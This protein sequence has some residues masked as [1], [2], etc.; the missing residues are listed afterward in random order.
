[1]IRV[2]LTQ[3]FQVYFN[4]STFLNKHH[5]TFLFWSMQDELFKKLPKFGKI[6]FGT[7]K[8]QTFSRTSVWLIWSPVLQWRTTLIFAFPSTVAPLLL[9]NGAIDDKQAF[10]DGRSRE[11]LVGPEQVLKI[12]QDVA[13]EAG[14]RRGGGVGTGAQD[15]AVGVWQVAVTGAGLQNAFSRSL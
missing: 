5:Q 13:V 12:L 14:I 15:G 7:S 2:I 1:M 6:N 3:L 4:S 11:V 10:D 8:Y 9:L